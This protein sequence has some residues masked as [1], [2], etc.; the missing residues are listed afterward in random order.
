MF[1]FLFY[2]SVIASHATLPHSYLN[3][4]HHGVVCAMALEITDQN[5]ELALNNE[6]LKFQN[7][8]PDEPNDPQRIYLA[9]GRLELVAMVDSNLLRGKS[10]SGD[11]NIYKDGT[12]F[13]K[14]S[15]TVTG[16]WASKPKYHL[17]H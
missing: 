5:F 4:E 3:C 11:I 17:S 10:A 15:C 13:S 2:L 9:W 7:S 1:N 6:I 14:L 16:L 8:S 12:L